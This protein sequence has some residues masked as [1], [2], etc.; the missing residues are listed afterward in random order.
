MEKDWERQGFVSVWVGRLQSEG[1]LRA[2]LHEQ[3]QD[4]DA[5]LSEF[6]SDWG[7]GWYDHDFVESRFTDEVG[8][9]NLLQPFSYADSFVEAAMQEGSRKGVVRVN[10]AVVVFNCH[11]SAEGRGPLI[12][13]GSFPYVQM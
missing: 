4:D 5:P 12:F 6:A 10:C 3:Y 8:L 7:L 9:A 1:D 2:Y 13:L 11:C